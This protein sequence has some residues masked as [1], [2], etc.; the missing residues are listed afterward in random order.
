MIFSEYKCFGS[1]K[2]LDDKGSVKLCEVSIDPSTG[3]TVNDTC[4][5]THFCN[6]W[7]NSFT[8]KRSLPGHCCPKPT[9]ANVTVACPIGVQHKT[10]LCPDLSKFPADAPL[11]A[12]IGPLC[13]LGGGYDCFHGR[14]CCPLACRSSNSHFNVNG[15]CYDSVIIDQPCEIDAQCLP[16]SKCSKH[17]FVHCKT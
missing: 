14:L 5:P 7:Q 3:D 8:N 9:S 10:G 1:D 4:P 2:P 16:D 11:P 15:R 13:P 6:N 17:S 12:D